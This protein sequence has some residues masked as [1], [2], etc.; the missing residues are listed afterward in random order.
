M[1]PPAVGVGVG[2]AVRRRLKQATTWLLLVVCFSAL[3]FG[4]KSRG[5]LGETFALQRG[6]MGVSS[7]I[8]LAKDLENIVLQRFDRLVA[9]G[10]I[11][12]QDSEPEIVQH[13]G[14]EVWKPA[15]FIMY[16]REG[17]VRANAYQKVGLLCIC[18]ARANACIVGTV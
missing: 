12:Y 5:W 10:E 15:T 14:F 3:A 6:P 4:Y 8:E 16:S 18:C 17:D 7:D 1:R 2:A 13:Q 11:F 9:R